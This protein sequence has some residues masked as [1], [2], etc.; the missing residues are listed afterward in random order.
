MVDYETLIA[1]DLKG[2]SDTEIAELLKLGKDGEEGQGHSAASPD[3]CPICHGSGFVNVGELHEG[4][5]YVEHCKCWND[6]QQTAR[7][8]K[9]GLKDALKEQTFQSFQ[10]NEPWQKTMA[11]MCSG[12]ANEIITAQEDTKLPWLYVSGQPG[13]GK[14]H[15][16]TAVCG[17]LMENGFDVLYT[18]WVEKSRELK[19]HINEPDFE[20][21]MQPL[22]DAGVLYL[23]DLAKPV[24]SGK[25]TEADLRILFDVIN[26]R[27]ARSIPTIISSEVSLQ[28]MLE[29]DRAIG[30]RIFEKAREYQVHIGLDK[31]KNWRMKM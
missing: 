24:E 11:Q 25:P 10:T 1:T 26:R 5:S 7:V 21:L 27:Y 6:K 4:Y 31:A 23:D 16:C 15:I 30:S 8:E 9:S 29:L 28:G 22:T 12:Y 13:C 18:H 2:M 20:T 19:A 3:I 17:K 14:T